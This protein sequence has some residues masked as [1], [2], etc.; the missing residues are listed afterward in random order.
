MHASNPG[1]GTVLAVL[2]GILLGAFAAPM[3]RILGWNWENTWRDYCFWSLIVFAWLFGF[4]TVPGLIPVLLAAPAGA[5][6]P[7]FLYGAGW[8]VGCVMFG[9]AIHLSGRAL[10]TAI[11]FGLSNALGALLPIALSH[12]QQFRTASGLTLAAGV[13]VM[14]MGVGLCAGR[15]LSRRAR[16]TMG[17]S[18]TTRASSPRA[19]SSPSWLVFLRQCSISH[20]LPETHF[21]KRPNSRGLG[22]LIPTSQSAAFR[23][24][25]GLW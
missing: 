18:S 13:V 14:L 19:F 4:A 24:S 15:A 25:A 17:I 22:W 21:D 6:A 9:L 3:K 1:L 23:C 16:R 12:P 20:S 8:G 10:G 5:L 2:A 11:V 7:V